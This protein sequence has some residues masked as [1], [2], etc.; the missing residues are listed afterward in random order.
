MFKRFKFIDNQMEIETHNSFRESVVLSKHHDA[1]LLALIATYPCLQE[2]Y[3]L[4]HPAHLLLVAGYN[5]WDSTDAVKQ[6]GRLNVE[7]LFY[8]AKQTLSTVWM[9]AILVLY[10]KASARFRSIFPN[11]MKPFN[12]GGIDEKIESFNT[13]SKNIG[14]DTNL[15]TIK[16]AVDTTYTQLTI[17]RSAQT[18]AKS[19]NTISSDALEVLRV[20]A[21]VLQYRNVGFVMD[22]LFDNRETVLATIIDLVTLREKAQSVYTGS[23]LHGK[24]INIL[25]HTFLDTDS[26]SVKIVGVGTYKLF[27][28]STITGIDSTAITVTANMKTIIKVSD[29][30]VTDFAN[31]RF[32]NLMSE[33]GESATYRIELL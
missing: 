15:T 20:N 31:H 5:S 21:M 16:S 23:I 7:I 3:D 4:Y 2:R 28:S 8:A 30:T 26:V 14:V 13:L 11:G 24:T 27:L 12:N 10:K 18:G 29:F 25:A 17:A 6:G 9:P 33:S 22:N 1:G 19:A 32:L